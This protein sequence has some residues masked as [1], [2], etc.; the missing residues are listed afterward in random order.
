[1]QKLWTKT[2]EFFK[3]TWKWIAGIFVVSA[4]AVSLPPQGADLVTKTNFQLAEE[5]TATQEVNK[6]LNNLNDK[7]KAELKSNEI[8]KVRSVAKQNVKFS[9][10][11][12]DVQ[13]TEI[14][15]S[16]WGIEVLARAW[17]TN[18]Q[19]GFGKD[20]TV[21]IERFIITN[22]PILVGD[23]AGSVVRS[24][25]DPDLGPQELRFR[26]DP[27]Q[28]I[29]NTIAH[30]V[31]VKKQK[32]GSSKIVNGK[33]GQTTLILYPDTGDP[34]ATTV[35]GTHNISVE[36][37]F[38]TT[39]ALADSDSV[40]GTAAT[41]SLG[42]RC[43]GVGM[44]DRFGRNPYIFDTSS[45]TSG[46]TITSA[47]IDIYD[48]DVVAA[49]VFTQLVNFSGYTPATNT[50]MDVADF[51]QFTNT[52]MATNISM[53]DIES[54]APAYIT[55]TLD[56][57]GLAYINK[58]GITPFLHRFSADYNNSEPAGCVGGN[59]QSA[60]QF[61]FADQAGSDS[62][63]KLTIECTG[64]GGGGSIKRIVIFENSDGGGAGG[65]GLA[66]SVPAATPQAQTEGPNNPS[67][68]DGTAAGSCTNA[69]N[70]GE[71]GLADND[72]TYTT[73]G[74]NNVDSGELTDEL[75]VSSFGLVLDG[76]VQSIDGILVETLAW[77][78]NGTSPMNYTTVQLFTAPGT[79]VGDNKATGELPGADPSSTYTSWG[80]STDDWGV[81][82]T[83]AQIESSGF[84]LALCFTA[85]ANDSRINLDHVRITVYYTT[86]L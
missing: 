1:M 49:D 81:T 59:I 32:F 24:W 86:I 53:A 41:G 47:T 17:D 11:D 16:K 50:T 28:A 69:V 20:G 34:G 6:C 61:R 62:D 7:E 85:D 72:T 71:G 22:P 26:E 30:S 52:L 15:K 73:I 29:L 5:C 77:G 65:G 63:P 4:L 40:G 25:T 3:K 13:I 43:S 82:W 14:K 38:A 57:D 18:G 75:R 51:D 37:D 68:D 54:S 31:K 44:W 56:A 67:V 35:D 27:K 23:P 70:W 78:F 55:W 12:Y 2:K 46:G 48:T 83:E 9:G 33:I 39:R 74:G 79:N 76:T 21:D 36:R 10:A 8:I 64:C 19:I 45:V 66:G 58:T 80:G 42:I 60:R 84:G